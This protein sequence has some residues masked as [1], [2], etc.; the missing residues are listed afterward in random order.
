MMNVLKIFVILNKIKGGRIVVIVKKTTDLST[1]RFSEVCFLVLNNFFPCTLVCF[2]YL[3]KVSF[4]RFGSIHRSY[5]L[6]RL[7]VFFLDKA[8]SLNIFK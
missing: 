7:L 1:N 6:V 2:Q 3:G 8:F 5:C 4:T